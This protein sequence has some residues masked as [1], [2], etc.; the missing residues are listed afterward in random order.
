MN[1]KLISHLSDPVKAKMIMEIHRREHATTGQLASVFSQI[2]QAT[3]YRHMKKMLSDSVIKIVDEVPIRGTVEKVYAL[4]FDF[5]K[6][7]KSVLDA[8][9]GE[10]YYQ[11]ATLYMLG[12]LEEFKEYTER[13]NIDLSGDGTGFSHVP[14]YATTHELTEVMV[15]IKDILQPLMSNSYEGGRKLRNLCIIS[16]PP[17]D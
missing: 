12:I 1:D 14:I 6:N 4:D 7:N 16:T 17:K 3:L 11:M 9:D 5:A 10:A 2:P 15:Q 13:E 8:N